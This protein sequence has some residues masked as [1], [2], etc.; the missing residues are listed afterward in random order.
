MEDSTLQ[1][2]LKRGNPVV[3]MDITI[4]GA[5]A[6]RIRMELFKSQVPRTAENFRQLCTG[7]HRRNGAPVGYKGARFHR[8]IRDFMVQGGDIVKGDG[9]G[10]T[11]IY[12]GDRFDDEPQGLKLRHAGAGL[13]SMANSGPNTNACQFFFTCAAAGACGDGGEGGVRCSAV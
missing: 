13:L 7:E 5:P 8:V 4:G 11:C 10:R 3:F 12:A 2:A 6:G 1:E 9:T